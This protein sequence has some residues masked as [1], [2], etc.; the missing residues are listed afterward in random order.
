MVGILMKAIKVE[1]SK[2]YHWEQSQTD[3]ELADQKADLYRKYQDT[4]SPTYTTPAAVRYRIRKIIEGKIE[5]WANYKNMAAP[6]IGNRRKQKVADI[7]KELDK[8]WS[9]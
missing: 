6:N 1:G 8:D 9:I 7:L 4:Y 5:P 3:I 2:N